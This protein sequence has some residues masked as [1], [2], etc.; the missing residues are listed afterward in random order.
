MLIE[1]NTLIISDLVK[2]EHGLSPLEK[3]SHMQVPQAHM[4]AV[5]LR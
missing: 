3:I 4:S 2:P 1:E 5:L